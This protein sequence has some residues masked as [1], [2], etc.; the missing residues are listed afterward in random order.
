MKILEKV[1]DILGAN[2]DNQNT[3]FVDCQSYTKSV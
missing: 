2:F 1:F 3:V